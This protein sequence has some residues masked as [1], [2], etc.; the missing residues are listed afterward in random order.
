V[1]RSKQ[2]LEVS[3]YGAPTDFLFGNNIHDFD[4]DNKSGKRIQ[5]KPEP[6]HYESVSDN[7]TNIYAL[8]SDVERRIKEV[9]NFVKNGGTLITYDQ[10]SKQGARRDTGSI[11]SLKLENVSFDKRTAKILAAR[12]QDGKF[13]RQI[14]VKIAFAGQTY[15]WYVR[16]DS[17]DG[18]WCRFLTDN[19]GQDESM[20]AGHEFLL[21]AEHDDFNN[22][23]QIAVAGKEATPT[24]KKR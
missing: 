14:A 20:W 8:V 15:I 11:P 5:E 7:S 6:V 21:F 4:P 23:N 22:R 2:V 18:S 19:F 17:K 13:G 9:T 24:G 16:V 10:T 1:L 12:P 3:K